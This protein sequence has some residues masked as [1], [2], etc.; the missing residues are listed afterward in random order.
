[1][2]VLYLTEA[3]VERLFDLRQAIEALEEAFRRLANSEAENVPRVRARAPGIVLHTMSAAAAYLG[4]VGWKFYTTTRTG[5]QFYV[6]LCDAETGR[7]VALLEAN[8]LG[9][10]RTGAATALAAEW[11]ADPEASE[12]GLFGAGGQAR[13]QLAAIGEVRP[14]KVAYVYSR[15][16]ARRSAFAD[17]MSPRLGID[18]RPVDRP[19]EAAEDLPIVITATTSFEPVF[20]G[21]DLTEGTL[22]CAIGSNWLN[23]A[24]IDSDVIRRADNIV[25]DSIKACQQEAGDFVDALEKGVFD[26]TR[27]AELADVVAGRAIGRSTRE[28]ITLFKSVGLAIEDVAV[29]ARLLQ[30][31]RQRG[32]GKDLPIG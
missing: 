6:G 31:A 11:M 21:M 8:R 1:M 2:G 19:I 32:M 18:V 27:A 25:C 10:L 3:D 15:A 22:V 23:R 28:S 5:M 24:E 29:G 13:V 20:S 12:V 16:E 14:I 26:W 4:F 30:T 9:Q 17:E 7:L